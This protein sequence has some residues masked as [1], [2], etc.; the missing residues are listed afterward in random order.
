MTKKE[1]TTRK[2][3]TPEQK[4]DIVNNK[5]K[6]SG[7]DLAKKHNVAIATIYNTWKKGTKKVKKAAVAKK[8]AKK[9]VNPNQNRIDFCKR[10]INLL[11]SEVKRLENEPDLLK[12]AEATLAKIIG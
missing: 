8:V 9:S 7:A 12:Q 5:G 10:W 6:V 11:Q 4:Q 1:T 2:R 3:L